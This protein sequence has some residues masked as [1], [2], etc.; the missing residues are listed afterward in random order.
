LQPNEIPV[1]IEQTRQRL[2]LRHGKHVQ[3]ACAK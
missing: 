2:L 3:A 1:A